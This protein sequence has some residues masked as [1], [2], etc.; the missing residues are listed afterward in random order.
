MLYPL[1]HGLLITRGVGTLNLGHWLAAEEYTSYHYR[2]TLFKSKPELISYLHL[3]LTEAST[4]YSPSNIMT[5]SEMVREGFASIQKQVE[6]DKHDF[7]AF[8]PELVLVSPVCPVS[9]CGAVSG[10]NLGSCGQMSGLWSLESGHWTSLGTSKYITIT[11]HR[12]PACYRERSGA[13]TA[14]N[15]SFIIRNPTIS[16][17]SD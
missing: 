13:V 1:S 11:S 3:K 15:R 6:L 10:G 17:L 4:K 12:S 14:S 9:A 5:S 16:H 2:N 7:S 8:L